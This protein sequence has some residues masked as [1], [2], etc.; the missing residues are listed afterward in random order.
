MNP[1]KRM[2][3]VNITE[4][5]HICLGVNKRFQGR[6]IL[7]LWEDHS[8]FGRVTSVQQ[9]ALD[10]IVMGLDRL[11][12]EQIMLGVIQG[13][14]AHTTNSTGGIKR[15]SQMVMGFHILWRVLAW[16]MWR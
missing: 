16:W 8:D 5:H 10:G 2:A 1:I 3:M 13:G 4:H 6:V 14:I 15:D 7:H 11:G 12:P 9:T